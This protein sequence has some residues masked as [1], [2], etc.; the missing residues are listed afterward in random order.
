M[1]EF[2]ARVPLRMT[3]RTERGDDSRALAVE[4]ANAEIVQLELAQIRVSE[5]H[6]GL[7]L[8]GLVWRRVNTLGELPLLSG[9]LLLK[10]AQM[11]SMQ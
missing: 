8:E 5:H 3:T 6:G 7:V 11:T 1:R 4:H 2:T 10:H 9:V